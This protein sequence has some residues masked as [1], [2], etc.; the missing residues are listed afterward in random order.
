MGAISGLLF[1]PHLSGWHLLRFITEGT[2]HHPVT[3]DQIIITT[4]LTENGSRAT[5]RVDGLPMV[6]KG[7]GFQ[8]IGDKG[9]NGYRLVRF[10]SISSPN[11]KSFG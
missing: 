8:D 4:N 9:L 3:M 10:N 7:S 1:L 5:G 11:L 2:I 6:G